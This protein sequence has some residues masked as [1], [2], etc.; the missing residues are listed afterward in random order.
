MLHATALLWRRR[1]PR[2]ASVEPVPAQVLDL[3]VIK[4]LSLLALEEWI[5]G[6]CV[7]L[8]MMMMNDGAAVFQVVGVHQGE[9]RKDV[10]S[11][12]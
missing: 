12:G 9:G 2:S 11:D 1:L 6:V 3:G 4:R 10:C 5:G 7:S 8:M